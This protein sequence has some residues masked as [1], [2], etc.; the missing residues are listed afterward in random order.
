MSLS[1]RE[2]D[3]MGRKR[4]TQLQKECWER[5]R[6]DLATKWLN[7]FLL[8]GEKKKKKDLLNNL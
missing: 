8:G 5:D 1:R 6:S 3:R 4:K 2:I 7:R